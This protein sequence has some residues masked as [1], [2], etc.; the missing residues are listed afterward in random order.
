MVGLSSRPFVGPRV[1]TIEPS[2]GSL[3][4]FIGFFKPA[5]EYEEASVEERLVR[6]IM[7]AIRAFIPADYLG[8][9]TT[10]CIPSNEMIEALVQL[11][12]M[13]SFF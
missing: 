2:S 1:D 13:V 10:G 9:S 11:Q 7:N 5:W 4:D 12:T 8:E 3:P 6:P